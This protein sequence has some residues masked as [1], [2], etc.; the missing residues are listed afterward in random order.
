MFTKRDIKEKIFALKESFKEQQIPIK[1]IWLFG[2]Y[3][4]NKAHKYS[5]IDIAVFSPEFTDNPFSNNELIQ[6]VK[7]LPQMQLHLYTLEDYK[8]NPF[9]QEIS[10]YAI[11]Y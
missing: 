5:D 2:S 4:K 3:A 6:Q 11:K 10:K 8:N 7:R 9:V 1:S